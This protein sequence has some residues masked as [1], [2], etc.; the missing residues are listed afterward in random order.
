M[1]VVFRWGQTL[2]LVWDTSSWSDVEI[3]KGTGLYTVLGLGSVPVV[4]ACNLVSDLYSVSVLRPVPKL[5]V[6]P[7][8]AINPKS[9]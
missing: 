9:E 2:I 1:R 5:A 4:L 3:Y 7:K 8:V 6:E